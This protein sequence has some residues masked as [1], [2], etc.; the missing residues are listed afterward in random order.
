MRSVPPDRAVARDSTRTSPSR[1]AQPSLERGRTRGRWPRP[2][3]LSRHVL[4]PLPGDRGARGTLT[5][6]AQPGVRHRP[7]APVAGAARSPG[8]RFHKGAPAV[9]TRCYF[10]LEP[11]RRFYLWQG[12]DRSSPDRAQQ[13]WGR[14]RGSDTMRGLWAVAAPR[15]R[16]RAMSPGRDDVGRCAAL[17]GFEPSGAAASRV[18]QE[19]A[20]PSAAA[21]CRSGR[22]TK[23]PGAGPGV[24]STLSCLRLH[25]GSGA[26]SGHKTAPKTRHSPGDRQKRPRPPP[27]RCLQLGE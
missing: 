20:T 24:L 15:L 3:P 17:S 11:G 19:A 13:R 14:W 21:P 26:S 23:G 4:S 22:S 5:H 6:D 1:L 18:H 9:S 12:P 8:K 27:G 2:P 10:A 25:S 7:C 16:G